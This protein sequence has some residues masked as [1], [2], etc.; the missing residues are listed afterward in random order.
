MNPI[1]LGND[2]GCDQEVGLNSEL[3][4]S[5]IHFLLGTAA[6][7]WECTTIPGGEVRVGSAFPKLRWKQMNRKTRDTPNRPSFEVHTDSLE[8]PLGLPGVGLR[9]VSTGSTHEPQVT[10]TFHLLE[11]QPILCWRVE[12][13]NTLDL[14]IHLEQAGM[15]SPG[16]DWKLK[17]K[18][19]NL[20]LSKSSSESS[21]AVAK[22]RPE[23]FIY[24]NGW[25]SWSP[26]GWVQAGQKQSRTRLGPL[27]KPMQ[28]NA[29]EPL[30]RGR[31]RFTSDMFGAVVDRGSGDGVLVGF[32]S[33]RQAFGNFRIRFHRGQ[34]FIQLVVHLDGIRL[35]P[36][37]RFQTD[38]AVL[39]PF[40]L[41]ETDPWRPYINLV[42]EFNDARV[43]S[44]PISGWCSWYYFYQD[45]H[46]EVI[47]GSLD[48]LTQHRDEIPLSVVQID[49]GWQAE[50]G[51]WEVDED[52]FPDGIKRMS[53]EIRKRG[54]RPGIWLA[55]LIS[56]PRSRLVNQHPEWI[57][58]T[59]F[60]VPV[61]PGLVWQTYG[62]ALDASHPEVLDH[63]REV[64]ERAVQE[65][66]FDYLK[67]DFL[68][69]G[70]LKGR[71]YASEWT[72]AQA[73]HNA[74]RV[75]R[76]AAGE[77]T[78]L[79]GCGCPL[80]SGIGIFDA[81][82]IGPDVAPN[83]RPQFGI[84]SRLLRRETGIPSAY[85]STQQAVARINLHQR[86]WVNDPDCFLLR[87]EKCD[88]APSQ[89][90]LLATIASMTGGVLMNSDHLLELGSERLDWFAKL[91]PPLRG[92]CQVV[93]EIDTD[94][95]VLGMPQRGPVGAWWIAAICNWS[96]ED[97]EVS[98]DTRDFFT[99]DNEAIHVFDFWN[100]RYNFI[101]SK[102]PWKTIVPAQ[103]VRLLSIRERGN[104]AMWVGD[105]L[106]ISQGGAVRSWKMG[107]DYLEAQIGLGR[108]A[109]GSIYLQI[110]NRPR[111]A[112]L[113]GKQV[114]L[115]SIHEDIYKTEID[116]QD[117]AFL[118][119]EWDW[120]GR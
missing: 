22:P 41:H 117:D 72:R 83:W 82:R 86:W 26:S 78:Y 100:E 49:D 8:S 30:P 71:R 73:L 107:R 115:R 52:R 70:A 58:R 53:E 80:G 39:Q 56:K 24:L 60:G 55:P 54:F 47:E 111:L 98:M 91:L 27:T 12:I 109:V 74:L 75:I 96:D 57:L 103:S 46:H 61:N 44:I 34:A 36:G 23:T 85:N 99:N 31:G 102:V 42:A 38:W 43:S 10:T 28:W 17:G 29:S 68:Y 2:I 110:P 97:R 108:R 118:C 114:A 69:A 20:E 84:F 67:L 18:Q 116:I 59:R 90:Q 14:P 16:S 7:I 112:T 1:D 113:D 37:A 15:I 21:G 77:G 5:W 19:A 13:A 101:Q 93:D 3:K 94:I 105:T 106:H 119:V 104:E 48:W 64:I 65:W 63:L 11:D 51:D 35:A 89:T 45:I 4:S 9:M 76:E 66:D 92:I 88:L 120:L 87:E 81:M 50:V 25:Q 6:A 40:S 33:Q 95:I 32:L 79:L 62:R